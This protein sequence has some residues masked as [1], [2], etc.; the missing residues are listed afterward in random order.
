MLPQCKVQAGKCL[1]PA[2]PKRIVKER[3]TVDGLFRKGRGANGDLPQLHSVQRK[4][5]AVRSPGL[6]SGI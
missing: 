3:S 6:V 1:R 4:M 5:T 2:V